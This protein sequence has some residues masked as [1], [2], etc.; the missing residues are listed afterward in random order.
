M[1][2]IN[3][4]QDVEQY[5][6]TVAAGM[7]AKQTIAA[8]AAMAAVAMV[9]CIAH[10]VFAIPFETAIYIGIPVCIPIM[11]PALGKQYGLT[12]MERVRG[13]NKRKQVV[14]FAA[15]RSVCRT[16]ESYGT[17]RKKMKTEKKRFH[18]IGKSQRGRHMDEKKKRRPSGKKGPEKR[19]VPQDEK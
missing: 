11:L 4:N 13:S 19:S 1:L 3:I 15:T 16:V 18:F 5:Q 9:V 17:E 7:N 6:E 10:F 14:A 2:S 12:V 8:A